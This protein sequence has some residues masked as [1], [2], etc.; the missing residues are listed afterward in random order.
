MGGFMKNVVMII[1][2]DADYQRIMSKKLSKEGYSCICA[3][4][5]D[6]A[7]NYMKTHNPEMIL[8]DIDFPTE[9]GIDFLLRIH[10]VISKEDDLPRIIVVSHSSND[11]VIKDYINHGAKG[12]I[13][14]SSGSSKICS[15]IRSQ[16]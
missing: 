15:L 8:L 16:A 6:E 7:L 12:F 1:D 10:E 4:S 11:N 5:V 2:D 3:Y 14:K 9:H 13:S